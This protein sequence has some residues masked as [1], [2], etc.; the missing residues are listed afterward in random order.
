M[1]DVYRKLFDLLTQRERRNF[2]LMMGILVLV[3]GAE[4]IGVSAV[5]ALLRVLSDT[6]AALAHPLLGS[7]AETLGIDEVG[8]FQLTFALATIVMVTVGLVIRASGAFLMIRY[9]EMRSYSIGTRLMR[10]Y[11]AQP[12]V[13]FLSRNSAELARSVLNDPGAAVGMVL[14]PAMQIL[15]SGVAALVIAGFLVVLDPLIAI[16][17]AVVLA[18]TYALIY[19]RLRRH[20]QRYGQGILEA[21]TRRFR[22][23]HEATGGIKEVKLLALERDYDS[24]FDA[25]TLQR[26]RLATIASAVGELPRHALEA[27]TFTVLVTA[28]LILL[29]RTDGQIGPAIPTLGVFAFATMRLLPALQQIYYSLATMRHGLAVL[30]RLHT[31][32]AEAATGRMAEAPPPG[33]DRIGLGEA[34]EL[35]RV[36]FA[37]PNAERASLR[38]LSMTI[39]ARSTIG[40]VGGTGAGKTTLVDLILGLLRPDSGALRVDGVALDDDTLRL[41]QRSL[42]YVPQSIFLTDSSVTENIAFG[43]PPDRV[44]HAAVERAARMAAIHDFIVDELPQGYDTLVGERGVRLSGGQR[45]RIGIARALYHDPDI[46]VFDEATSALDTLTERVVMEAVQS[47]RDKK[48]V[49][50][51]AHRLGTVRHCDVIYLLD[52]GRIA[53][54]GTFEELVA[55]SE[56]FR[57]MAAGA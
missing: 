15:S 34:I 3:A 47:L 46:L 25:A 2:L 16:S 49:I 26:T 42:G 51:I 29:T 37:Y 6:E 40:I 43:M 10:A 12:Y 33:D 20:L 48:T 27:L 38:A 9:A 45:Q 55:G 14:R 13:W 17:A 56:T 39:P 23:V 8:R 36:S 11:L 19:V 50:L 31:D 35:D 22:L 7:V 28:V 44:D 18:G 1:L 57:R 52:H 4:L 41:W 21:E 32:Y 24:R 30:D 53:A 5:L 54:S